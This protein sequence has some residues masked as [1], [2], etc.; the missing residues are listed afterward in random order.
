MPEFCQYCT[1]F[2]GRT[3][4]STPPQYKMYC[5]QVTV[6]GGWLKVRGRGVDLLEEDWLAAGLAQRLIRGFIAISYI[7][8]SSSYLFNRLSMPFFLLT[9]SVQLKAR[10]SPELKKLGSVF[11]IGFLPNCSRSPLLSKP[12]ASGPQTP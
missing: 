2:D 10:S 9:A 12:R 11:I 6:G 1:I 4:G 8:L 5:P 3:P 7:K